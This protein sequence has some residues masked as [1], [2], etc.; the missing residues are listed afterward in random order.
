MNY[1]VKIFITKN[2]NILYIYLYI[3]LSLKIILKTFHWK[4]YKLVRCQFEYMYR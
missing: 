4:S 2:I 3:Y 1:Y